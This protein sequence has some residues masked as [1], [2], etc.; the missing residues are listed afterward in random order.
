MKI[1]RREFIKWSVIAS[2]V[3]A[4]SSLNPKRVFS[5]ES[6]RITIDECMRMN[7]VKMAEKSYLIQ[8][9]WNSLKIAVK[10][11]KDPGSRILV[12]DILKNPAPTFMERY[13][14]RASRAVLRKKLIKA[15]LLD[16]SISEANFLPP[17]QNPGKSPQPFY[18]AP[19]SGYMSH[20]A[21]PGGLVTHTLFNVRISSALYENYAALY[22]YN[23]DKN[24]IIAAQILHDLHKPWVFQWQDDGSLRSEVK[25]AGTGEHHCYSIA[26]SMYRGLPPEVVV[27]QACAHERPWD[28]KNEQKIVNW[29]KAA[30]ILAG[31]D[32]VKEGYLSKSGKTLPIPRAQEYFVIHLGD[33]DWVL[34]VPVAKWLIPIIKKI[35]QKEYRMSDA[36]IHGKQFNFFRN[37]IFSQISIMKLYHILKNQGEEGITKI[38]KDLI[39]A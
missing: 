6:A 30:A 37:Y 23:L 2:S 20:H 1:K 39:I 33:H 28:D 17:T 31:K 10:G 7:P 9:A 15:R 19:G 25:L 36:D 3:V 18:S 11:I 21:Y 38:I 8:D 26:E 13:P 27:A 4:V 12:E 14:D 5:S 24:V 34:T 29:I 35:A 32:P 22:G 16:E